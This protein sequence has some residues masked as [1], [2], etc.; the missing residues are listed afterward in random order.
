MLIA[1]LQHK[2]RSFQLFSVIRDE[3]WVQN[4][5]ELFLDHIHQSKD[6][7]TGKLV[8]RGRLSILEAEEGGQSKIFFI[9]FHV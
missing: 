9:Y 4:I 6:W 7:F 1:Y 3:F 2:V 5:L 8:G